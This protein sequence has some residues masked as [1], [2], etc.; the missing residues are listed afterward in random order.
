MWWG[1]GLCC[2]PPD[3]C[4]LVVMWSVKSSRNEIFIVNALFFETYQIIWYWHHLCCLIGLTVNQTFAAFD[5]AVTFIGV[6]KLLLTWAVGCHSPFPP[7]YHTRHVLAHCY[8]FYLL[9][10][11]KKHACQTFN[12]VVNMNWGRGVNC[13]LLESSLGADG[14]V[15]W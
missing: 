3:F 1:G 11:F 13:R 5:F 4:S 2:F 9:L 6:W 15:I 7:A 12:F 10:H 8:D 14:H